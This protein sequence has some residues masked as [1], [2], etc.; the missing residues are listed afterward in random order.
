MNVFPH[1]QLHAWATEILHAAGMERDVAA[2]VATILVEA[3]LMG[4]STHG[5]A[6][7]PPYAAELRSGKM[8]T[9]GVYDTISDR[10]GA[11][12][13]DGAYSSGVFLTARAIDEGLRR[14]D[15]TPVVTFAI[16]RAHHIGCL[17]AYM[18]RV[19]ERGK[20]AIIAASDPNAAIVAPFGGR[21]AVYSPNPVA[22]GVPAGPSGP[23][24]V[25]ISTSVTAAG[26][27]N[28]HRRQNTPL[29]GR[30]LLDG[31]GNATDDP[32]AL[33]G[34]PPGT[35]LPL[36]G[37]D[38]GYKGYA[39]GLMVEALTSGLAG[40]GRRNGPTNW[41]TSVFVQLFDPEAFGGLENLEAEMAWT[42][43]ACRAAEPREGY[44]RV[45]VP[46]DRA[47]QLKAQQMRD[48][49]VLSDA[50]VEGIRKTAEA[51]GVDL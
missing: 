22:I 38:A 25:D 33:S 18:P 49:V 50:I 45:R 48:G 17:A 4:H 39:L 30:W 32:A 11:V 46:G 36:G 23:I 6:L 51:V 34:D 43:A 1:Q 10:P 13:W 2:I 27:V 5:L 21:T 16:R 42:T 24:I 14:I 47:L 3:D 41:G 35:I 9:G 19:I 8:G 20:I 15:D 37:I 44:E 26:V 28:A 31:E 12:V 40:F 7:V 29:P